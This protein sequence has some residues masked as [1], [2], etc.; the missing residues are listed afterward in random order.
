[1]RKHPI[2]SFFSF[3]NED[4]TGSFSSRKDLTEASTFLSCTFNCE[5]T[6]GA[7]G[8]I[9]FHGVSSSLT[10]SDCLFNKCSSSTG[11][12]GA[13]YCFNCG[14][15]SVHTSAFI[16]CSAWPYY[17]AGGMLTN[18]ALVLPEITKCIFLSCEAGSD[19]G[20]L[21]LIRTK[22]GTN[23]ENLPVKECRFI[24]CVA[25]GKVSG[26]QT[27]E[28]DGGGLMYWSNDYTFGITNSLFSK[29][30]SDLRA[31]ALCIAINSNPFS[32]IVR[33]CF[34]SENTAKKGNNALIYLNGSSTD[35]WAKVFFHSFT[36]DNDLTNSLVQNHPAAD[37]VTANWLPLTT[38]KRI[39]LA[40][41]AHEKEI[42]TQP[43]HMMKCSRLF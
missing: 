18:N 13:V 31:G 26:S 38:I 21:Y 19:C 8:A 17:G 4:Y 33:F 29:C 34:F 39:V 32:H 16:E 25:Y 22:G 28:A 35:D 5:S 36:S 15:I 1:M 2:S 10:I 11:S 20:G 6:S 23:G 12:G 7:G 14:Q 42:S 9:Y 27:N 3:S 24:S 40:L 43:I 37:P 30:H 41:A